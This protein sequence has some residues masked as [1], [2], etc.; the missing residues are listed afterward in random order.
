MNASTVAES[1]TLEP[2]DVR[3]IRALQLDP[4][5]SYA[6]IGA[7]LGLTEGTVRRRYLRLRADGVI[8]VAGVLDPGALG[9]SRW[10][11]RLRCR[12]DSVGG[13]ATGLARRDDVSW[14]AVGAAGTEITCA[15]RSRTTTDRDDLIGRL[16]PRTAAVLDIG[17]AV[18]LH[19]FIGGRGHYWATLSGAL[20]PQ[21]EAALGQAP[22][23]E[24]AAVAAVPATLDAADEKLL[25]T[26]AVDGRAPLSTLAAA[27][28]LTPGRAARRLQALVERRV[29][30]IDVEIPPA[31]L[32]LHTRAVL[33]LRIHPAQLKAAGRALAQDPAIPFA[34][35]TSGRDNLQAVAHCRDLEALYELATTRLGDLPG[36]RSLEV[37]PIDHQVKQ[38]A[39]R[40]IAD[41]LVP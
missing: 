34:A 5:A 36:L 3:I 20:T 29:V 23:V 24:S 39:T 35:A 6:Q 15:V 12:P 32:G 33:L 38:A 9:Q 26:L 19:Q 28:N 11:V 7:V 30:H 37:S 14:I 4:R 13:I 25:A 41:R 22:F 16:L 40:L 1:G 10:L 18:I 17:A 21:E 31:A 8:H 27:A 2:D